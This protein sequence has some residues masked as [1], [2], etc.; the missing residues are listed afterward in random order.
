VP[1]AARIERS[2]VARAVHALVV[3]TVL[4]GADW[5]ASQRVLG[6]AAD[7]LV[8][9]EVVTG[10]ASASDEMIELYNPTAAPISLDG[11]EVIYV[12]ASGATVSRRAAWGTGAPSVPP[13]GH[14]LIAHEA[15]TFATIAD[16]VYASGMAATGGSVAIRVQGGSTAIDAVGWGTAVSSWR[17]GATV[18][19]SITG[20]SIE[21]LPGGGSGSTQDT[22]DNAADFTER[23]VPDP[24]N[25]ASPPTPDPA[26]SP[27]ATA[28]PGSESPEPSATASPVPSR[29]PDQ[30]PAATTTP[31][32]SATPT[33]GP[34]TVPISTARS[35]SDGT[36]VTIEGVALTASEFHDGGGF[37]ADATAG[38][39][40]IVDGGSF[41]RGDRLRVTGLVDDRFSQRTIRAAADAVNY[42]GLG[43]DPAPSVIVTGAVGEPVEATLVRIEGTLVSGATVLTTGTAFDVD[44]GSGVARVIVPTASGIDLGDWRRDA[45]VALIGV[46]GQRDSTGTGAEGYRI[47]PRGPGDVL[48]VGAPPSASATPM[49]SEEP[50]PAPSA[51][52]VPAGVSTIAE[53][54]A[55]PKNARLT[56]RGVVTLPAGVV[57]AE[58][59]VIQDAT[60]AI[61]LRLGDE[62]GTLASGRR[63]QVAGARSTKGGMETLRVSEPPIDLGAAAAPNPTTVRTGEAGEA[64]EALLVV[65]RGAL[66]QSARRASSGSVTFEIDDGSGPL[67]V[68]L[69]ASLEAAD[70]AL[71]AGTWVE[72]QG[73][74]GQETTGAQPLRGY[75]I[76]PASAADVR[77]TAPATGLEAVAG[78]GD[79]RSGGASSAAGSDGAVGATRGAPR[80]PATLVAGPWPELGVGGVL[81]D[82]ARATAVDDESAPVVAALLGGRRPPLALE[83]VVPRAVGSEPSTGIPVVALGTA[84]GEA[85][86]AAGPPDPPAT[87]LPP[88]GDAAWVSLVGRLSGTRLVLP[89]AALEVEYRCDAAGHPSGSV[90]VTGLA[91]GEPLR[92]VVPCGAIVSAPAVTRAVAARD[93]SQAPAGPASA[94]EPAA[95]DRR[96]LAA[97]LLVGSALLLGGA[98][99]AARRFAR[100]DP[101]P[102]AAD[103]TADAEDAMQAT[104]RLA[105]VRV[106][107]DQ[108]S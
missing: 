47:M 28:S 36:Q 5:S 38:I 99:F 43:Q 15:G 10:G 6:A 91:I 24:Q 39:A 33:P 37:V 32:P 80:V 35:A 13:A 56:V 9:S 29:T 101:D 18:P 100:P 41:A 46:V 105:L 65:A 31:R 90:G 75:R 84:P 61:V 69:G 107:Q 89:G 27:T 12:T 49:P 44:D 104:P 98:A 16:A 66:V 74:L 1:V 94:A 68:S 64:H 3:L 34:S 14:I 55:A 40:V 103:T 4:F 97:V 106:R 25:L 77:V 87:R 11:L 57:D 22:D 52:D 58:T 19:V 82:G 96:P 72:V 85:V 48:A 59:V 51:S 17:E 108:G 78:G 2:A 102:A 21:R 88:A 42:V 79:R 26:A 71:T 92:L 86:A 50:T 93:A 95:D 62:A 70:E 73:V 67:R 23:L 63:V 54:R 7:H 76:W 8:V 81:W 45:S 20:S 60:G 53:A 30:T 83:L